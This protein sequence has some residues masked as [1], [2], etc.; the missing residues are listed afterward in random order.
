MSS[1][2][3][4]HPQ[5]S[6]KYDSSRI[7]NNR[8]LP[9]RIVPSTHLG[10]IEWNLAIYHT[11]ITSK[12]YLHQLLS[13]FL[14]KLYSV[15][16]TASI[17]FKTIGWGRNYILNINLANFHLL[18]KLFWMFFRSAK[19]SSN[20]LLRHR[21]KR[22]IYIPLIILLKIGPHTS[23][24]LVFIYLLYIK[25]CLLAIEDLYLNWF[26]KIVLF[27]FQNQLELFLLHMQILR[28]PPDE[29]LKMDRNGSWLVFYIL[30]HLHHQDSC[31]ATLYFRHCMWII[32]HRKKMFHIVR[33]TISF[34]LS[35]IHIYFY[36]FAIKSIVGEE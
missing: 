2:K 9:K 29:I 12:T 6:T 21:N 33:K 34:D 22:Q 13:T 30:I 26:W 4:L 27:V 7:S 8:H 15:F 11:F 18:I 5:T 36:A 20:H 1:D 14:T 28:K 24:G 32:S 16:T 10:L 3:V 31:Y 17:Y 19:Y 23:K 35:E 25:D